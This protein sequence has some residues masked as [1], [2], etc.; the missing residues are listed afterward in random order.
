MYYDERGYFLT[1]A[2]LRKSF[3]E[4]KANGE[5]ECVTYEQYLTECCGKNG[6]LERVR[7]EI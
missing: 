3:E 6:A 1:D 7:E 5:T 4:L 2:E